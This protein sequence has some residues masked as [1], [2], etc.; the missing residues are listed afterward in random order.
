M[1]IIMIM[2][3]KSKKI[4]RSQL[5]KKDMPVAN[6]TEHSTNTAEVDYKT[7]RINIQRNEYYNKVL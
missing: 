7:V 3:V 2:S 6:K 4:Q 5:L 1:I